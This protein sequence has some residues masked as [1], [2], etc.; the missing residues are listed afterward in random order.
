MDESE[1]D[2]QQQQDGAPTAQSPETQ[3]MQTIA[4]ATS[5]HLAGDLDKAESIYRQVLQFDPNQ[6][7]ALHLLG[8]VAHQRGNNDVAVELISKALVIA[9]HY[10]DAHYNLALSLSELG[11]T[12]EALLSYDNTIELK[13]EFSEAH[14]NRGLSLVKLGRY[15][16]AVDSYE[17]AI[18]ARPDLPEVRVSISNV[19]LD[20]GRHEEAFFHLQKSLVADPQF[21][22]ARTNLITY[23]AYMSDITSTDILDEA[24]NWDQIQGYKGELHQHK[25][26][27]A[28]DRRLRVGFVSADFKR[29][30][31]S[32]F[33]E[34]I[35]AEIDTEKLE[36]FAYSSSR[37][38]DDMTIKLQSLVSNWRK[39]ADLD[40]KQLVNEIVRDEVDILIDLSCHTGGS[41]LRMFSHKPAPIQ[42]T[43]LG[44]GSTTGLRAIDYILCDNVIMPP[45]EE[46]YFTEK[47]L[48]LPDHW[49]CYSPPKQDVRIESFPALRNG[50]VTFGSFNVLSK[51]TDSVIACWATILKAIPD[52]RLM[53][54]VKAFASDDVRNITYRRFYSYGI[55]EDRVSLV[56]WSPT[57]ADHLNT[58]NEIDIALDTFPYTGVTTTMEALWMGTPVLTLSGDR[59]AS[60]MGH[61]IH[62]NVGLEDWVATTTDAYVQKCL[63]MAADL[64]GLPLYGQSLR[65]AFLTSPICDTPRFARNLEN[66]LRDVWKEWCNDESCFGDP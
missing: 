9:P 58:Y 54:K 11:R 16:E 1:Q 59:F 39:V 61:S 52:S 47:P 62:C 38:E 21:L 23:M 4:L 46:P 65:E 25:N 48:R 31:V 53:L 35:F 13:P 5:H 15:L 34:N 57:M 30:S 40:D 44:F 50:Y 24:Q 8:V 55:T 19:L 42:I 56:Y 41:R 37:K 20:M 2:R 36:I 63:S 28:P 18:A 7:E 33:L 27:K 60:R 10:V 6:P 22:E 49:V 64:E 26:S 3:I 12:E 32:Y 51:M 45:S 66:A 29:H 43:W 17:S 14:H